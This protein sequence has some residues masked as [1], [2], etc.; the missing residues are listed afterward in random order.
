MIRSS[1]LL[2]LVALPILLLAQLQTKSE[3]VQLMGCR[4]ELTAVHT[5]ADTALRAVEA[6]I[7]E[8]Q[9]I[10]KL[11]S[12]WDPHS[13][14]SAINRAAGKHAVVVDQELFNLIRRSL[15]VSALTHGAFDLSFAAAE[16]IWTFDRQAYPEPS[17]EQVAAT[18]D[19]INYREVLLDEAQHSVQL[20]RQGM[21]IGFGGI[22]KGYAANRA[23]AIMQ[24]LGIQNGVVNASGDLVCWGQQANGKNWA[25]AIADPQDAQRAVAWLSI[26]EGAIVTSGDYEKYLLLQGRRHAHIID[27][28]T[29]YPTTGI[30]SVSVIC[31]D[32]ELADALA[33]SIFVLGVEEGL[34]LINQL[35]GIECLIIDEQDQLIGSDQL[36]LYQVK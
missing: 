35:R 28:R 23:K 27:P 14:T 36:V 4:F 24:E 2:L 15:K 34:A 32:A 31:P 10:E 1:L 7:A 13:Q 11:I 30:K 18:I 29:G 17:T 6:G 25:V 20:Q 16:K 22:G 12:S 33:T 21:K 26:K 9:R 5:D 19:L 8:I 3:I